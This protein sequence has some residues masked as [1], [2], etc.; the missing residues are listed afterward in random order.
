M[1]QRK[2][3]KRGQVTI[4][5]L[6]GLLIAFIGV[7][8]IIV[9]G[10]FSTNL[11]ESL[12]LDIELGQVNLQEYNALTIGKFNEMV[13]N[14]ADFWGLSIIFGMV[15][16]LLIGAYFTRNSY[17]KVGLI[18]DI[19][20]IF[21]AFLVSLY[22]SAV[23]SDVVIALSSSGQDFAVDHLT[24]TN[25]FILNLPI[26][27]TIIGVIMMIVFHGAIPPKPDELNTVPNVVT[28]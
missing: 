2:T 9:I 12:D 15:L 6:V 1:D 25:F 17:P 19:G 10:F 4:F 22:L 21:L 7:L 14:N 8:L 20:T 18:I 13:V 23:Y 3:N 26:F 27:V 16:G 28:G 11:N 24:K 5:L